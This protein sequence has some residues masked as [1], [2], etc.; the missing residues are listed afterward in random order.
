MDS[1]WNKALRVRG[2]A[3]E[4][5]AS[6]WD[7]TNWWCLLYH[8]YRPSLLFPRTESTV[9]EVTGKETSV[10]AEQWLLGSCFS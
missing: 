6:T 1:V 7:Q 5:T 8:R 4:A 10:E 2:G 3:E 9:L